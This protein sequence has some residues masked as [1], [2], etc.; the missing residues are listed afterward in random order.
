[1][2]TEINFGEIE[3]IL[4]RILG[5]PIRFENMVEETMKDGRVFSIGNW[6]ELFGKLLI[7]QVKNHGQTIGYLLLLIISAAVLATIAKAFRNRQIS[8]TGF[9]MIYL[10]VFLIMMRSFGTC[11][12]LTEKVIGDLIDFMRVLMPA[13]LMAAA[14]GAYRTSAVIYYEGFLL[15]IYYLQKAVAMILLPGIRCYVLLSML[16]HLGKEEIFSKGREGLKKAILFLMKG[17]IGVTAGLQVIQGMI[18]PAVDEFK[19]T[20]L[21][22]GLSSLGGIGNIMGNVTDVIAGSGVLLKNGIGV[23][24]AVIVVIICLTPVIQ[25]G[26]YAV[27]YQALAAVSEPISDKRL[28]KSIGLMGEGIGL[29]VRLLF[30][31]CALFLLTIAIICI[32]TGG[33]R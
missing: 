32:M 14:V 25:T 33:I 9:Y 28:T 15:L 27:F 18:T 31:V 7:E 30:T 5:K 1:M 26:C 20:A 24:A 12:A 21:S 16:G 3:E 4:E 10:L 22:K 8:D 11:Y 17:M 29:L 6:L 2:R 23:V 19:Q 13:F